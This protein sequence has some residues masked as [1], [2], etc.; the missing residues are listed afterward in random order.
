V[1]AVVLSHS[2]LED[3]LRCKRIYAFRKIDGVPKASNAKALVGNATHEDL[4]GWSA[5]GKQ[6]DHTRV[7]IVED[8]QGNKHP[9]YPGRYAEKIIPNIPPPKT[10]GVRTERQFFLETCDDDGSTYL[11][12]T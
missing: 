6:P 11:G 7:M 12:T 10:P 1:S 2:S 5:F 8:R 3:Y 9:H 4:E